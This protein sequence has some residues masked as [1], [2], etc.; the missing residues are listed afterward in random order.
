MD[1]SDW[2]NKIDELDRKLVDLLNQRARYAQEIGRLKRGTNQPVYEPEREK[3][4]YENVHR[5]NPGPLADRDL[6][7]I[8]ERLIDVMRKIQKEEF[9][10]KPKAG[11][12][13]TELEAE[14]N[15]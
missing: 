1:I 13:D 6:T 14:V 15:D 4:I 2:R 8:Y 5:A 3:V 10:P 11:A 7:M 9:V 12:S